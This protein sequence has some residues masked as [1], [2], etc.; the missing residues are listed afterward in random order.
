MLAKLCP[1]RQNGASCGLAC[2][3]FG[4]SVFANFWSRTHSMPA[5]KVL[6]SSSVTSFAV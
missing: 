1:L 5:V 2:S 3:G 4:P 6:N